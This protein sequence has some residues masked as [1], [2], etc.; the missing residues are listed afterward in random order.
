M[1]QT[2]TF[3]TQ[4]TTC[5][6]QIKFTPERIQQIKNLIERGKSREEIAE[7]IGVTV[8]SL[9]V[10]CSRLGIGLRQ[11]IFGTRA[12]MLERNEPHSTNRT[13][14]NHDGRAL[15]GPIKELPKQNSESARVEEAQTPSPAQERTHGIDSANL[16]LRVQYRGTERITELP[17]TQDM[18]R[19]L[20][21]EAQFR[22]MCMGEL[23]GELITGIA[24]QDL[25]QD[26][27]EQGSSKT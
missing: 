19:Q 2:E 14:S 23:V 27:L 5:G 11:P 8:S 7:L 17:L 9:Q 16:S 4:L 20:A 26:V 22:G 10:I 24:K 15:I 3:I 18:I 21:F 13:V 1:L 6:K 25:F 12:G